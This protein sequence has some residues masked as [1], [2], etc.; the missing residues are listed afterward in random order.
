MLKTLKYLTLVMF[1]ASLLAGCR[2]DENYPGVEYAPQMYHSVPYEGL[3]Q[4]TEDD[5][6]FA[7]W[8]VTENSSPLSDYG[9]SPD[10]Q[11]LQNMLTPVVGTVA[12]QKYR[13]QA[14]KGK[15]FFYDHIAADDFTS[16]SEL[17][18]PFAE[19]D[20]T[21]KEKKDLIADGKILFTSYCTPCHGVKGDGK[22]KVGIKYSG[23]ANLKGGAIKALSE[24]HIFH[25]ITHGKGRMWAHKTLLN[26]EE[27]WKVVSYV[28]QV[29][30]K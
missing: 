5:I 14:L 25:V 22:G 18:N 16:A 28:K 10:K 20:L 9:L 1:G 26:P 7:I 24:G 6:N 19:V 2:A 8:E 23:V 4:F 29:I 30:Q 15:A 12:R 13:T 11:H 3:S 17:K 27:R 21:A